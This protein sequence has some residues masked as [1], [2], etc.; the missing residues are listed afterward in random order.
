MMPASCADVVDANWFRPL[1]VSAIELA[2]VK[3]VPAVQRSAL[4]VPLQLGI[5]TAVGLAVA[6]VA[7]ASTEFAPIGDR[8]PAPILPHAGA[9][10]GPVDTMAWP[11]VDPAGLSSWIGASVAPN[12]R[13]ESASSADTRIR[14]MVS[15]LVVG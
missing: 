9:V 10:L 2:H 12:A 1:D 5:A 3:P 6:P 15:L 11:E 4:F 13:D 14:F 7:F 8:L